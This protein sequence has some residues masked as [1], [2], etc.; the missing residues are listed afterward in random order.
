M[1]YW[2]TAL[3]AYNPRERAQSRRQYRQRRNQPE[4]FD[5]PGS[6]L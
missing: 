5:D 2:L 3:R 4:V 1:G 6:H